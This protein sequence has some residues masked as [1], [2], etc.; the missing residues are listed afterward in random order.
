MILVVGATGSLG[1]RITRGL[2]AQ[3]KKVRFLSRNNPI[4]AE[5]VWRASRVLA[6]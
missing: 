4:S 1:G 3:G 5:S 6:T 2:R